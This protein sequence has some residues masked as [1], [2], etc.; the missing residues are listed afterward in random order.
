MSRIGTYSGLVFWVFFL[1]SIA[2][3]FYVGGIVTDKRVGVDT[4]ELLYRDAADWTAVS[5]S[6]YWIEQIRSTLSLVALFAGLLFFAAKFLWRETTNTV[7]G[8]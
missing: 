8:E 7:N 6:T 4:F 1:A 5:A 2:A 3:H